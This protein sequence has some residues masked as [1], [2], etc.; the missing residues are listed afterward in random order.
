[1]LIMMGTALNLENKNIL[2]N[3]SA[4][5]VSTAPAQAL[6][7]MYLRALAERMSGPQGRLAPADSFCAAPSSSLTSS[8]LLHAAAARSVRGR[9]GTTF[10]TGDLDALRR[11]VPELPVL[12]ACILLSHVHISA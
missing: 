9:R 6:M 1:M 7:R 8:S 3:S 4:L 12:P 5:S 11:G 2:R 10:G